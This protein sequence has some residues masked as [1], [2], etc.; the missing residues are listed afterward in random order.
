L[1]F[2][3]QPHVLDR[4][5]RLV[6]EGGH[7]LDLIVGKWAHGA[8]HQH[9]HANRFAFTQQRN[10][11]H[12]T[13]VADFRW[14]YKLVFR[15]G[16]N[17]G[18]LN[19]SAFKR[20]PAGDSSSSQLDWIVPHILD[21]H[22]RVTVTSDLPVGFVLLARNGSQVRLAQPCRRFDQRI[23]HGLQI[24]GRAAD[25]LEHVGGSGLLLQRLPQFVEQAS[26]LDGDDRLGREVRDQFDL[27]VGKGADLLAI[28]GDHAD[29]LV[30]IKH[31]HGDE[32]ASTCKLNSADAKRA[33]FSVRILYPDISNV[34]QLLCHGDSTNGSSWYRMNNR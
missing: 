12:R 33:A 21:K 22:R 27:L 30:L 24:E 3:E 28:D 13:V 10:T 16:E 5:H 6:G 29:Q 7:Q 19:D 8:S 32:G 34:G 23:E 26:V 15:I 9:D 18:Y 31:R 20:G 17:V 14:L 11:E 1:D 4:D 2:V 25:D